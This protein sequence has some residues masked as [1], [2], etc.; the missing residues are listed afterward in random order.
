[1]TQPRKK[2]IYENIHALRQKPPT[3]KVGLHYSPQDDVYIMDEAK[4]GTPIQEIAKVQ[5]RTPRAI[6]IRVIF[7]ALD[8]MKQHN[9]SLEEVSRMFNVKLT[10][11]SRYHQR[12]YEKKMQT[13][14]FIKNAICESKSKNTN[15]THSEAS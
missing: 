13:T 14:D 11:L 4:R 5:K 2:T 12:A 9:M 3:S 8:F 6:Q 7:I 1:M 10:L 15:P